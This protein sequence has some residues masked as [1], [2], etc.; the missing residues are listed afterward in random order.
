VPATR[1]QTQ[2]GPTTAGALAQS[3]GIS[4]ASLIRLNPVTIYNDLTKSNDPGV[5]NASTPIHSGAVVKIG[6]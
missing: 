1:Y 4:V 3:L 6:G 2:Y 5:V